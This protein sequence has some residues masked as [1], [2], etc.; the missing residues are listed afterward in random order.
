MPHL[1][2]AARALLAALAE[3]PDS[4]VIELAQLA[5]VHHATPMASCPPWSGVDWWS[6]TW[7]AAAPAARPTAGGWPMASWLPGPPSRWLGL[8]RDPPTPSASTSRS[9]RPSSPTSTPWRPA[10]TASSAC[11]KCSPT[12]SDGGPHRPTSLPVPPTEHARHEPPATD[13]RARLADRA[14]AQGPSRSARGTLEILPR[15]SDQQDAVDALENWAATFEHYGVIPDSMDFRSRS[16]IGVVR[17]LGRRWY[18]CRA[19]CFEFETQNGYS[20]GFCYL[21]AV[22]RSSAVREA[23]GW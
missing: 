3:H 12:P 5:G 11:G 20:S 17:R 15:A 10:P 16:P 7:G 4:T 21:R 9:T 13:N 6:A 1:S 2:P 8:D 19:D 23:A 14:G 22:T 18:L